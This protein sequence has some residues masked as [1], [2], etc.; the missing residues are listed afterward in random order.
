[1]VANS[2]PFVPDDER[3]RWPAQTTLRPH[4]PMFLC[5]GRD[6]LAPALGLCAVKTSAHNLPYRA[7]CFNPDTTAGCPVVIETTNTI[8]RP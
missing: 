5:P 2:A 7:W 6:V 4:T 8:A 1:M 3:S